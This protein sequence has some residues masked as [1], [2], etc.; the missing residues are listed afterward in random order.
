MDYKKIILDLSKT[1]EERIQAA[2]HLEN[3]TDEESIAA[4]AKALETDPS[5]IVRHECAFSLGETACSSLAGLPLMKAAK[6]D[7][8]IFV[9]H[10]SLLAL[11]TLGEKSFIPFI[12][13]FLHDKDKEIRESAE[14]A[15]QRIA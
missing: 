2:F 14:I 12:K 10:E 4:L 6:E 13:E 11:G 8:N 3:G 5:P 9:R 7:P 15:L 1:Q